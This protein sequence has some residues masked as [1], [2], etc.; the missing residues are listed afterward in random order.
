MTAV[1]AATMWEPASDG[2]PAPL[3][4]DLK[5]GE[6]NPETLDMLTS[7]YQQDFEMFGYAKH[8]RRHEVA[9]DMDV[10]FGEEDDGG[11]MVTM[12]ASDMVNATGPFGDD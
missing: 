1:V 9:Y 6:L 12:L 2:Q 11:M 5:L 7:V 3:D 8:V 4:L 10:R